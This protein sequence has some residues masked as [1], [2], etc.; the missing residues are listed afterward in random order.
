MPSWVQQG[1]PFQFLITISCRCYTREQREELSQEVDWNY[2]LETPFSGL[3]MRQ[4]IGAHDRRV[5]VAGLCPCTVDSRPLPMN[6]PEP[7][8]FVPGTRYLSTGLFPV[9]FLQN[10]TPSLS[11]AY[12]AAH[13][14]L[15]LPHHRYALASASGLRESRTLSLCT[16]QPS[17]YLPLPFCPFLV[18]LVSATWTCQFKISRVNESIFLFFLPLLS[19]IRDL[20]PL[21]HLELPTTSQP[22]TLNHF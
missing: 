2:R 16:F 4:R 18:N 22:V 6:I 11:P 3:G 13:L 21:P 17:R 9:Q 7:T 19:I 8:D 10:P 20:L 15:L 12:L 5:V 1:L 14:A